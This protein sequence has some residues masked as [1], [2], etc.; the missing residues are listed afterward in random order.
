MPTKVFL[1]HGWS[2]DETATYQAL[3]LK[4][5]EHG[6]DLH[7]IQLGRYVSLDDHVEVQDIARALHQALRDV[8][9]A[10]PWPRPF[11]FITHS[12]GALVA[13]EWIARHYTGS[14]AD[15]HP[16]QN[17]VFL[18]GPHFGSR[19]AHH[20]R[21]ML[22]HAAY[23]GATGNQVLKSLELGSAFS[24]SNNGDWLD[25]SHWKR[26]G[27]RPFC[28]V[29]DRV[30]RDLVRSRVFPAGYEEGSDMVVRV[31]AANLN[32][33]RYELRGSTGRLHPVGGID[34]VPFAALARYVHSGP[35]RGIMN[36]ITRRADP[37]R[38][39]WLN[40]RLVLRC[41]QVSSRN[42]YA[43]V[44][45]LLERATRKTREGRKAFSQLDFRIRDQDGQPIDDYRLTLGALVRGE[46]R[47]SKTIAHAHKNAVTPSHFTLF[48]DHRELEPRYPYFL[49]VLTESASP[50]YDY[51]PNP[52]R[53]ELSRDE[54]RALLT[55]DRSAQIDVVMERRSHPDLF[56]F[57][58]GDD[59]D[60]H[61]KWDREGRVGDTGLKIK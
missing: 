25:P 27:V 42:D 51:Q 4:L 28:L 1:I 44:A 9:G 55:P 11:H 7:E 47:A 23:L 6:Y 21:S 50:L 2:V 36:S 17:V 37:D 59:P 19:L 40:L 48:V 22:A 20:G 49:E 31:A 14:F 33:R 39:R 13:K 53:V 46:D 30:E 52:L 10:P 26:K 29:G 24:W 15:G 3:H 45:R 58:A 32:F 54:L 34:E 12:T 57:H 56:R 35:E 16:L 38:D 60:L 43:T 61:L 18:A 41:L 8:L 5:A